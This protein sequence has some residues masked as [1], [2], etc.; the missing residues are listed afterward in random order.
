MKSFKIYQAN[1][2]KREGTQHSILNDSDLQDFDVIAMTEPH[3][4]K[5]TE[6]K[7]APG[8]HLHR[9]IHNA[10]TTDEERPR[11]MIWASKD[12]KAKTIMTDHRDIAAITIK[13]AR[14]TILV[15]SVYIPKKNNVEDAELHVRL[16]RVKTLTA[17][18]RLA[19]RGLLEIIVTGDFNRHDQLWGGNRVVGSNREGEGEGIIEMMTDLNLQTPLPRGIETWFS[20]DQSQSSTIDLILVTPTLMGEVTRCQ[21]DYTE[22]G[23]DHKAIV[24]VFETR[25]SA[26][27]PD[28]AENQRRRLWKEADWEKARE[29]VLNNITSNP[30]PMDRG[31]VDHYYKYITD[32]IAPAV[33]DHIPRAKPAPYAKRWW[34]KELTERRREYTK[35]KNRARE[36][37]RAGG[38]S[39]QAQEIAERLGKDF[40][41]AISV[42]KTKHWQDFIG[43]PT[44]IWKVS[45]YL[46]PSKNSLFAN[47]SELKADQGL[48][49]SDEDIAKTLIQGFFPTP[50]PIPTSGNQGEETGQPQQLDWEPI[51]EAE[52]RRAVFAAR[53]YRAPGRDGLPAIVWQELWDVLKDHITTLFRL[54]IATGQIPKEWKIAK[55]IP[56]RKPDKGNYA[57]VEAY[58]PISLI[59]TLG[60]ALEGLVAER[61]SYYVE[62]HQLLP[63]T[64]FGARKGRSTTQALCLLQEKI[65]QAWREKKTL[66]LVSFDLKGAYNGVHIPALIKRLKT[67]RIPQIAVRW[68]ESFCSTRKATITVNGFTT[69]PKNLPNAGLPQGSP[70]S[71]I[72]F[73]FFNADLV[74]S[75]I[76]KH[77]GNIAF[78]DDYTPWVA[79]LDI[80]ENTRRLQEEV[81][82]KAIEWAEESGATFEPTKTAFIHFTRRE[83]VEAESPIRV[84]GVE[85]YP[86]EEVK[87]LGVILDKKLKFDAHLARRGSKGIKAA[88][89]L[90]RIRGMTTDMARQLFT[91]TVA[92]VIDYASPIWSFSI[93][94]RTAKTISQIQRIGTQAI[95]GAFRTVALDRAE[96]EAGIQPTW[97]RHKDQ[98]IKFWAKSHT[99]PTDNP[100]HLRIRKI[101]IHNKRFRSPL[102][103]IAE[104]ALPLGPKLEQ[105]EIIEP[106]CRAPWQRT[107]E[108]DMEEQPRNLRRKEVLIYAIGRIKDGKAGIGIAYRVGKA[109]IHKQSS[110]LGI[111]Q[112]APDS[113]IQLQAISL[114]MK[115]ISNTWSRE[116]IERVGTIAVSH[117]IVNTNIVV[118][119][120]LGSPSRQSSQGLYREIL[121]IWDS[122]EA[123]GGPK[124]R[125][126]WAPREDKME[127]LKAARRAAAE[128]ASKATR[129]IITNTYPAAARAMKIMLKKCLT[130]PRTKSTIDA[131]LPGRHVRTLYRNLSFKQAATLCQLRTGKSRL[132]SYLATIKAAPLDVCE[133]DNLSPETTKHFLFECPRWEYLRNDL[134]NAMGSR[135]GD[136]S[137]A[138]GGRSDIRDARGNL[139]DGNPDLWKPDEEIV[140]NTIKFVTETGRL[141]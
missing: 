70:L 80:E 37:R 119:R 120:A 135:W 25:T 47:I 85:V 20:H 132:N 9:S 22:H 49:T 134:R 46:D 39:H 43:E 64:H 139:I 110:T 59:A 109:E 69:E 62:T 121:S 84:N 58:R 16:E 91:A 54:S 29:A 94:T 112:E 107:L 55:I 128:A 44:N 129:P 5:T 78:V 1:V 57:L 101:D 2:W 19:T 75:R 117:T 13:D 125:I 118:V 127:E 71:P 141:H 61:L 90:K 8:F 108:I 106:F 100:M 137:L 31:D 4:F 10:K 7:P 116:T 26:Q 86:K 30:Q 60:K 23:S 97:L 81:V 83:N 28:Q 6:W 123:R 76:N 41:Q 42:Q 45:K 15:F 79:G 98:R 66:S 113:Y 27:A 105:M 32:L 12:I 50:P 140:K 40:Q 104:E 115:R 72:L 36:I 21:T 87:I 3:V 14:R 92:P 52:V 138:V 48:V 73:L 51:P 103:K 124:I 88:W 133:C 102:Q 99:L 65:F 114:A 126:S 33:R 34:T 111:L 93:S 35:W 18:I 96:I 95:I 56:F 24:T 67:R 11:A 131:A 63:R 89:A 82:N 122:I 130:H 77:K 74:E 17:R 136:L 68:I 38:I 53:P